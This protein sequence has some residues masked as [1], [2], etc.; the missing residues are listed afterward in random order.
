MGL[1]KS[2]ARL[3]AL[4][5]PAGGGTAR[6]CWRQSH[7]DLL[8]APGGDGAPLAFSATGCPRRRS[9]AA[10]KEMSQQRVA[11][12]RGYLRRD[13]SETSW[14]S[15]VTPSTA[16]ASEREEK[17]AHDPRARARAG[18]GKGNTVARGPRRLNPPPGRRRR[19]A[20]ACGRAAAAP[21]CAAAAAIDRR[22]EHLRARSD[23]GQPRADAEQRASSCRRRKMQAM[24]ARSG[25]ALAEEV[26]PP[27]VVRGR[28]TARKKPREKTG[29]E[30][31]AGLSRMQVYTPSS[32]GGGGRLARGSLA[33]RVRARRECPRERVEEQAHG[34]VEVLGEPEEGFRRGCVSAPPPARVSR[35]DVRL[36]ARSRANCT[37][38]S[39]SLA[40][41]VLEGPC[42]HVSHIGTCADRAASRT[43]PVQKGGD[44]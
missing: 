39:T 2:G 14:L 11:Q 3:S 42:W 36:R 1:V 9:P 24:L 28:E 25:H 44:H 23:R 34:R 33:R 32:T 40:L 35:H 29:Q 21:A 8:G 27:A 12:E 15:Y 17:A 13:E 6:A 30:E 26:A 16:R 20:A 38:A 41:V 18:G 5:V 43:A 31:E 22:R 7:D 10:P 37:P 4:V 19:R